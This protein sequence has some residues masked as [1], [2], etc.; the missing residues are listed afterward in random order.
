MPNKTDLFK[1]THSIRKYVQVECKSPP[2][3][4]KNK[5]KISINLASFLV[6]SFLE[7]EFSIIFVSGPQP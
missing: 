3:K 1:E 2:E 5:Q 6:L 4:S 7:G